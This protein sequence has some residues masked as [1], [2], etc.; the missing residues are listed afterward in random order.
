ML[1]Q[2]I[3]WY[4][5]TAGFCSSECYR[6]LSLSSLRLSVFISADSSHSSFF[7]VQPSVPQWDRGG[8]SIYLWLFEP[9]RHQRNLSAFAV[10][11][12]Y[13]NPSCPQSNNSHLQMIILP[14]SLFE[15]RNLEGIVDLLPVPNILQNKTEGY[16]QCNR[17]WDLRFPSLKLLS[18]LP[19][20]Q[21]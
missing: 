14:G 3:W 18:F 15:D 11:P 8:N 21:Y 1:Q 16:S 5:F 6:G 2:K 9:S 17:W 4:N 19:S 7:V 10:L 13:S 12:L 20:C